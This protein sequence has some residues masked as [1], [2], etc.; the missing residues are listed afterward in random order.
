MTDAPRFRLYWS[1]VEDF[2][3]LTMP[4]EQW[5]GFQVSGEE[6]VLVD[7]SA[8][9]VSGVAR[10]ASVVASVATQRS[11][12]T[13][14]LAIFRWDEKDLPTPYNK[15]EYVVWTNLADH[16]RLAEMINAASTSDNENFR[17][18]C[19]EHVFLVKAQPGDD[20]WLSALPMSVSLLS[21]PTSACT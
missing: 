1:K 3:I 2:S 6:P 12:A 10:D 11:P 20:H 19:R 18:F 15:D 17:A 8:T 16:P 4:R 9:P 21:R 14:R 7:I 5:E 13:G